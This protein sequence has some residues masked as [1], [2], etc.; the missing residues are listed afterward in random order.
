[1]TPVSDDTISEE[2]AAVVHG[3]AGVLAG[4]GYELARVM[5]RRQSHRRRA[6]AGLSLVSVLV[7][8]LAVAVPLAIR[9]A[10][11]T[12]P[13]GD[14]RAVPQRLFYH[15][16]YDEGAESGTY[17]FSELNAEGWTN[18]RVPSGVVELDRDGK[19]LR[20]EVPGPHIDASNVFG[21]PGGGM[22]IW[23]TR[24]RQPGDPP[25]EQPDES[26]WKRMSALTVVN[27]DGTLRVTRDLGVMSRTMTVIGADDD[28]AYI[29]RGDQLLRHEFGSGVERPVPVAARVRELLGQGW[30]PV[31][32]VVAN[33]V[34]L[35]QDGATGVRARTLDLSRGDETPPV[36]ACAASSM[37][38]NSLMLAPSGRRLAC[39]ESE[40]DSSGRTV[41]RLTITDAA[42]GK[43]VDEREFGP[44]RLGFAPHLAWVDDHTLRL[45][46]YALPD[47]AVGTFDLRDI[48]KQETVTL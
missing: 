48:L 26:L 20:Y 12:E 14:R 15:V 19:L 16:W 46:Y 13:F 35:S 42:T 27:P 38:G 25:V 39:A 40:K 2:L 9:S 3:A 31:G 28:A 1:M 45:A 11:V 32:S 6:V 10:T 23:G 36:T 30:N 8:A 33:R 37:S 47:N 4:G 18:I 43:R 5:R 22:V 17:G 41:T 21:L 7:M 44:G 29:L 24:W 34:V